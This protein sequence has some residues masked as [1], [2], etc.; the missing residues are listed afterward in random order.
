MNTAR[1]LIW[2]RPPN[3][4]RKSRGY[5]KKFCRRNT[6]GKSKILSD[7]ACLFSM[8]RR[9]LWWR[10]LLCEDLVKKA[11]RECEHR[12]GGVPLSP[13][14]C[15]CSTDTLWSLD[16]VGSAVSVKSN[17]SVS[18]GLHAL[19]PR[20]A[21]TGSRAISNQTDTQDLRNTYKFARHT[22]C[23]WAPRTFGVPTFPF[24]LAFLCKCQIIHLERLTQTFRDPLWECQTKV[25]IST[26]SGYSP[27]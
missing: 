16:S 14:V 12:S 26:K 27:D 8:T 19:T 2:T 10:Q 9:A 6:S 15:L 23:T 22:R 17:N 11:I 1:G 5:V 13:T 25:W 20:A 18:D 4:S 7:W 3:F 21:S 24:L